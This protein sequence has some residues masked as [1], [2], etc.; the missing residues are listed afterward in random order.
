LGFPFNIDLIVCNP[1]WIPA[2]H[3]AETN[4]LD[5]GVYDSPEEH[6]LKS[7]FNFARVHLDK[8]GEM[9]LV[10]SDLAYQLG[11]QP[12]SRI[13]KLAT[14]Y[15]MRAELVDQTSLPLNKKTYDPLRQVKANS[16]VQLFKVTK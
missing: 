4:P 2:T 6:F 1:P 5:N 14:L 13:Q 11:L 3:V 15:G 8:S 12:E 7:A 9:L 10:Y 16:K